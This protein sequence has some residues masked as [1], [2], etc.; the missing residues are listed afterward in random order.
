MTVAAM[1][2]VSIASAKLFDDCAAKAVE[3]K[4]MTSKQMDKMVKLHEEFDKNWSELT[5]RQDISDEER[6]EERK[7]LARELRKDE[8][9]ILGNQFD[10]WNEFWKKCYANR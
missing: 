3:A 8:T 6:T 10:E 9:E 7:H 5:K 4:I 2:V 1:L